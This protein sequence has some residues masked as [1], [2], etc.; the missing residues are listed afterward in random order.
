M[1]SAALMI[2]FGTTWIGRS[3]LMG[4]DWYV[5]DCMCCGTRG[6]T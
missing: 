2:L 5:P 6:I 4:S 3:L 1:M